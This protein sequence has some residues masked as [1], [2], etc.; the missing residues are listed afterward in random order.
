MTLDPILVL[1]ALASGLLLGAFYALAASGLAVAFGLA[2]SSFMSSLRGAIVVTLM[3][4]ILV[5]PLL[6]VVFGVR[7]SFAIHSIWSDVPEAFPVWL[8]LAYSRG[9]FGLE[10][11]LLLVALPLLLLTAPAWLLY[12]VTV[13]NLSGEARQVTRRV[14]D[15]GHGRARGQRVGHVNLWADD[16]G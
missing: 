3:L 6:Y 5:G 2:V 7:G 14:E 13:A 12:E 9:H 16:G 15:E 4:A 1:N 8:P 10:Y 11:L